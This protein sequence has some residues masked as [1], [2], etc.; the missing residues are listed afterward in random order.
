MTHHVSPATVAFRATVAGAATL[1]AGALATVTTVAPAA[2]TSLPADPY[3][4]GYIGLCNTQGQNVTSGSVTTKPFVWKAVSS[5]AP[6]AQYQGPG[7]NVVLNIYQVRPGVDPSDWSGDS[8]TAASFYKSRTAPAA[9]A[10]GADIPLSVITHELPPLGNGLYEL[11][12]YYGKLNYGLY[13]QSYPSALIQVSGNTWTVVK[14]GTVDCGAAKAISQEVMTGVV[15]SA[16]PPKSAADPV[17]PPGA[18]TSGASSTSTGIRSGSAAGG[19]ANTVPVGSASP[20]A[21]SSSAPGN[22]SGTAGWVV[23]GVAAAVLAA[24]AAIVVRRRRS[25]S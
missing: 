20:V 24:A 6:P 12:M 21:H 4:H 25:A 23:G 18:A 22:S 11:R 14:G 16:K 5:T 19:A 17:R 9:Q 13:S 10:T 8:L 3:A 1:L 2:A 15:K 7:E